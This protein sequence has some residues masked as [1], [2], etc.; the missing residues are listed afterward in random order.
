MLPL[1]SNCTTWKAYDNCKLQNCFTFKDIKSNAKN[2]KLEKE[3]Y[4]SY[5]PNTN[6][7]HFT[8]AI[9]EVELVF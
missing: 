8:K 4:H 1:L 9:S 7:D 5:C 6:Y 3:K 2:I